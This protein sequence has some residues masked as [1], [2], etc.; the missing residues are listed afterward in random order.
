MSKHKHAEYIK[1]WADGECIQVW[2]DIDNEWVDRV[3]PDSVSKVND[4]K[5]EIEDILDCFDFER[6]KKVM[7]FLEWKWASLNDVPE[8]W[9]L[10]KCARNLLTIV[11]EGVMSKAKNN[12]DETAEYY[13]ATGGFHAEATIYP[14]ES[15]VYLKIFFVISD[16]DNFN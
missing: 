15:K 1:A 8:I 4:P 3:R 16:W 7:D 11:C 2:N 12:P 9:D 10:R 6:V 13:T 14:D 5:N